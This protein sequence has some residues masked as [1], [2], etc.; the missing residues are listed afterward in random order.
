M[1]AFHNILFV[2][3]GI[4]DQTPALK[5]AL[6][7]ATNN[8]ASLSV[9]IAC[10]KLPNK[11]EEYKNQFESSMKEQM[12]KSIQSVLSE[13]KIDEK[14]LQIKIDVECNSTPAIHIIRHILRNKYDLL[15]KE[16]Q[17]K[18]EE[19]GFRA[20]DME[21]LRKCPCPVWLCRPIED[22]R[23]NIKV[24][25]AIDPED[26][27]QEA[28]DLSLQLLKLSRI[29]A[30]T[31]SGELNIISCWDYE[32]ENYVRH[33]IWFN[34]S[35]TE[36]DTMVSDIE[37]KHHSAL[38]ALIQKANIQ[39]KIKIDHIRGAP[40]KVIPTCLKEQKIDILVMGTVARTGIQG[41]LIGNTAE[42]II[43]KISCSLLALKPPGFASS[44]KAY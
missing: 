36:V 39:G 26:E 16:V 13:L 34:L 33:N 21:L 17:E 37:A 10:P 11:M 27:G 9:L 42:N 6:R 41:F 35:D 44:V 18:E 2:S 7:L 32:F 14:K 23:E 43:Q 25:V 3:H 12:E 15:I 31:C 28:Q 22:P 5:Q 40:D 4:S 20:I 38:D 24:A 29:L 8:S 30:D 19:K 1:Q